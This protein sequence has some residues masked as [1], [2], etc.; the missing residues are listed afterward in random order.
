MKPIT[1]K[2]IIGIF[3]RIK[4]EI[5]VELK[6]NN[7]SRVLYLIDRAAAWGYFYNFQYSDEEIEGFIQLL[8]NH[9]RE[10]LNF[11]PQVQTSDRVLLVTSRVSDNHELIRQYARALIICGKTAKIIALGDSSTKTKC[12]NLCREI[13]NVVEIEWIEDCEDYE[14]TA[15]SMAKAIYSYKPSKIFTHVIPWDVRSI[16]AVMATKNCTCFNINFN[17]HTFWIGK[18]MLDYLIEFRPY[19]ATISV[20]KRGIPAEKLLYVPYYPIVTEDLPFQGFPF[21]RNNKIVFFSGGDGYKMMDQSNTFFN[22]I[23]RIL[24]ENP[25]AVFFLASGRVDFLKGKVVNLKNHDRI[26]ISGSRKDIYAVFVNCDIYYGTYPVVGALMSEYAALCC[27]PIVARANKNTGLEEINGI[28]NHK[29]PD[30]VAFLT[31]DEMCK[32]AHKLCKDIDFRH[33]EGNR[34][35]KNITSREEFEKSIFQIIND[36][37]SDYAFLP[38]TMDY[39]GIEKFYLDFSVNYADAHV[40]IPYHIFGLKALVY[41][42]KLIPHFIRA[43]LNKIK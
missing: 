20:E 10:I 2:E 28:L 18:S 13:E 43:S 8:A 23:D 22:N 12:S 29:Y 36:Q 35:K 16:I 3:N 40:G 33:A 32:Y 24:D 6:R 17:D 21:D 41:W 25:D 30:K 14:K 34:L 42:P 15:V 5:K 11:T 9:Y 7:Y 27:K 1:E 37:L 26:Y 31:N 38:L 19:G 4:K 39:K